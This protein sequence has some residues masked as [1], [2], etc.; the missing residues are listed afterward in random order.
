MLTL[1]DSVKSVAVRTA[2]S[3]LKDR[4]IHRHYIPHAQSESTSTPLKAITT[5]QAPGLLSHLS[6]HSSYKPAVH[7]GEQVDGPCNRTNSTLT[8]T[9]APEIRVLHYNVPESNVDMEFVLFLDHPM[10]DS[11]FGLA[12]RQ[13]IVRIRDRL[14]IQGDD[15]LTRDDD[16][17]LSI[18]PGECSIWID[19]LKTATGRSSMTYKTLLAAFVG[20]WNRLYVERQE[21]EVSFR[22]Q[23]AG[24]TAGY[25][26]VR[27]PQ[28]PGLAADR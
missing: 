19:S 27:V 20:L 24:L 13:G 16:P 2:I 5:I 4:C 11:A 3:S 6:V 22:I 9:N 17:F 12:L 14:V 28:G 8:P 26:T 10:D 7:K 18:V 25:G 15:W 23:V 21:W 1:L